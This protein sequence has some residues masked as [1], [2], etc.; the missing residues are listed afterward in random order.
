VKRERRCQRKSAKERKGPLETEI[1]RPGWGQLPWG[2]TSHTNHSHKG[3]CGEEESIRK[4]IGFTSG[5]RP[6]QNV[7]CRSKGGSHDGG[8]G[9]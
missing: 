5:G 8:E 6:S 7:R 2:G 4:V 9:R 3:V 1:N